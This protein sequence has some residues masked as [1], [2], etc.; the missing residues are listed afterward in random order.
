MKYSIMLAATACCA[1]LLYMAFGTDHQAR[2]G[3]LSVPQLPDLTLVDS[4]VAA[5]FSKRHESLRRGLLD[6]AT[7]DTRLAQGF[8]QLGELF[9]AYQHS[10]QAQTCYQNAL[11]LAIDKPRWLYLLANVERVLGDEPESTRL[12]KKLIE[13]GED[14]QPAYYWLGDNALNA[15]RVQEA[16]HWFSRLLMI[17]P[18]D[19]PAMYGLARVSIANGNYQRAVDTL[20]LA[21]RQQPEAYQLNYQLGVAYRK[22]GANQRAREVISLLASDYYERVNM[23]LD[24]PMMQQ[25]SDLRASSQ[26]HAR[27]GLKALTQGY[28]AIA[29]K[30]FDQA[31]LA[32]PDRADLLYNRAAALLKLNRRQQAKVQLQLNIERVPGHVLNY[33]L[34]ARLMVQENRLKESEALLESA[35]AIDPEHIAVRLTLANVQNKLGKSTLALNNYGR[36]LKAEPTHQ[37]ALESMATLLVLQQR[38]DKAQEQLE[39]TF[40]LESKPGK[41]LLLLSRLLAANPDASYRDGPRALELAHLL[42]DNQKLSVYETLAMAHAESADFE[43]AITLQ[44]AAQ[45]IAER[46]KATASVQQRITGRLTSYEQKQAC[47]QPWVAGESFGL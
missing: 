20:E 27:A 24:D 28:Y 14:Y 33:V 26:T 31:L 42:T 44:K 15:G 39:A 8:G 11:K 29:L 46:N 41:S 3:A 23:Q 47:R 21:L 37:V 45:T 1:L 35:V 22:M 38:Y 19:V 16:E 13:N 40:S 9:Q 25:V 6:P 2:P 43:Q 18:A 32:S 10:E 5:Q 30:H 4:P 34:L 7:S 12:L 36:I 17:S